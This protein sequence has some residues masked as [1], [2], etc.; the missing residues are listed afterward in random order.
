MENGRESTG[1]EKT[2]LLHE[3]EGQLRVNTRQ[4]QCSNNS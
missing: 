4:H 1:G 2:S 3:I